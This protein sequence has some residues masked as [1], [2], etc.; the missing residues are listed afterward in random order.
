MTSFSF[1]FLLPL[2]FFVFLFM[3]NIFPQKKT[4]SQKYRYTSEAARK[5]TLNFHT[6]T[7]IHLEYVF[8]K[9]KYVQDLDEDL[10]S[11]I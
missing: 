2:S 4:N 3:K 8:F 6:F 1:L 5:L 11:I 9:M 10:K 7:S